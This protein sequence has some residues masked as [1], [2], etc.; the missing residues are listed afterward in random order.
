MAMPAAGRETVATLEALFAASQ[1]RAGD[2]LA[3]DDLTTVRYHSQS[4]DEARIRER[5]RALRTDANQTS[6]LGLF[7]GYANAT[8]E[9]N[10]DIFCA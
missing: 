10:V 4:K 8:P 2:V 6:E 9:N 3:R 1:W 5:M 7:C